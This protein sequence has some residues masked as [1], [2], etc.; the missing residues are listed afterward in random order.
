MLML[1]NS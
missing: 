1:L